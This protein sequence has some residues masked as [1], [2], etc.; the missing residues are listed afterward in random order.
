MKGD[1]L[2]AIDFGSHAV[3][4]L[5]ARQD[6]DGELHIMGHGTAPGR[7]CVSQGVI[8]DL[9]AAQL[10]LKSAIAQAEKE[11]RARASTFFCAVNGKNVETF[12]REG[13]V[14]LQKD[15]VEY[16]DLV[17]AL[18]IASNELIAP[19]KHITS[20]ITAQEWYVDDLRVID[21]LGIRGAVLKARVHFARM[22][23]AI[24]DNLATCIESQGREL[25]DVIFMPLA[26]AIGCLTPEDMELGV[27]VMDMGRSTT[28]LAM[29]RDYRIL[30]TH[31]FEW[32]GYHITR[33]VAAGLQ[34]S[35]EEARELVQ[36]YGV[37][38]SLIRRMDGEAE[39]TVALPVAVGGT[40]M[41]PSESPIKLK[42]SVR[43]APAIVSR[44]ELDAI[45]FER[46]RELMTKVRQHLHSRGLSKHLIR[47]IVL[48]G[49]A[50]AIK[51]QVALAEAVFQVPARIGLPEGV[52]QL[53][54]PMNSPQF[55]A[56]L[57][58]AKHGASFRN[59]TRSGR[60]LGRPQNA[61][62]GRWLAAAFRR[63]FF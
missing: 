30:T 12:I 44:R 35:F 2:G 5:I 53:P 59:A 23:S 7:G 48:T 60:V 37:S 43:G 47:G 32:G 26:S 4:V 49:G 19:G 63:Y 50:S 25:E 13:N 58:V 22:P 36:E 24:E 38:E 15:V 39:E 3:R 34:V 17:E 62:L 14:Q 46:S 56:V 42:T 1:I 21:P 29:Y 55:S 45:V 51:N 33:D 16:R 61:R 6:E 57:G 18:D 31:V 40:G 9:A 11:A 54:G 10:A 8:Q 27:G 52:P 20:S 28:G 41:E